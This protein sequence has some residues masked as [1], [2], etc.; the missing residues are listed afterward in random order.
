MKQFWFVFP[1]DLEGTGRPAVV[2]RRDRGEEAGAAPVP[3]R[4]RG[5]DLIQ[6]AIGV[7]G[8]GFKTAGIHRDDMQRAFT[9]H[10]AAQAYAKERAE[11]TPNTAFGIYSCIGVY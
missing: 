10:L 8:H 1:M 2:F 11:K 6:P 7:E 9:T 3:A 5:N 4:F